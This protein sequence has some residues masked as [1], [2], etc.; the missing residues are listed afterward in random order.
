MADWVI[1]YSPFIECVAAAGAP[2]CGETSAV[3]PP[4]R[5]QP[6]SPSRVA[7]RHGGGQSRM[8]ANTR[9]ICI[10]PRPAV[11]ALAN[12]VSSS[13]L[14]R[15]TVAD[16]GN[17]KSS[18]G[19]EVPRR[20][21]RPSAGFSVSAMHERRRHAAERPSTE[22]SVSAGATSVEEEER[23]KRS[24]LSSGAAAAKEESEE[25]AGARGESCA[26]MVRLM[27]GCTHVTEGWACY[28]T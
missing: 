14:P 11:A 24:V 8:V 1:L 21:E 26:Y 12:G 9:R 2:S 13:T 6:P 15:S 3:V 23:V 19:K 10:N 22:F 27:T 18:S 17:G 7:I 28:V 25:E 20:R 16:S 4:A 5:G